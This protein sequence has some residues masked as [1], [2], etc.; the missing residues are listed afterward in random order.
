MHIAP[1][2]PDSLVSHHL[3]DEAIIACWRFY[4]DRQGRGRR[5]ILRHR[6]RIHG[7]SCNTGISAWAA[8]CIGPWTKH[9]E[10]LGRRENVDQT[11]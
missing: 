7:T 4:L 9:A 2:L 3:R 8:H 5:R 1:A 6:G 11:D 10:S